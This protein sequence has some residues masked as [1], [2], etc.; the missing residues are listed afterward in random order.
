M[1]YELQC[2]EKQ[3]RELISRRNQYKPYS[4][5]W[6]E[7]TIELMMAMGRIGERLR[8]RIEPMQINMLGS[9][10]GKTLWGKTEIYCSSQ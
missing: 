10:R 7:V 9:L 5:E 3:K 8:G 2:L 6:R 1:I 4:D